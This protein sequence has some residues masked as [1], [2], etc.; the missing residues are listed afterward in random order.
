M[1]IL[2]TG[3][4]G[5][6]GRACVAAFVARGWQVRA[7]SRQILTAAP[8]LE[9]VRVESLVEVDWRHLLSG[10]DCVL[11]LAGVAHQ[12]K[13]SAQD[14]QAINVEVTARLATAAAT[15]GVKRLIYLSS[16]AVHGRSPDGGMLDENS[17]L[18]PEDENGRTKAA[19][20]ERIRQIAQDAGMAWTIVRV[21]LVYGPDAPGNFR[22]LVKLVQ[23][24]LPLP[25]LAATAPRSY[26]GIEN[27]VSLLI[28][29]VDSQAA[30]NRTYL[31]SDND[32]MS[33]A[34]LVRL[35]AKA[36]GRS[37]RLW[38]MPI[39]LIRFGATLLGRSS[40]AEGLLGRLQINS[41]AL[42]QELGWIPPLSAAEG[43]SRAMKLSDCNFKHDRRI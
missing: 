19:A 6:I 24:G 10:I 4:G 35:M 8:G 21:P 1:H 36:I 5:F 28:R 23:S 26:I 43:I 29:I 42:R 11:H 20:E 40:D 38:W 25:L 9:S 39:T 13:T 27:L 32:D 14:Y 3:A 2:V 34:E 12:K 22:R 31:A 7:I 18:C 15:G 17:E 33:T 30:S 37:S 41:K 16:I